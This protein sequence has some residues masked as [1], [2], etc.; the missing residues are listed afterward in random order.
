[1]MYSRW[2]IAG[3]R[4]EAP[5]ALL[6]AGY[7]PLLA[8]VLAVRGYATPEAARQFLDVDERLLGDPLMLADMPQAVMRLTRAIAAGEHIAVYGDYDV[9]GITST[10][11]LT[12]YLRRRGVKCDWYIPDRLEEGYGVNSAAIDTLKARGVTLIV[13]VDCGV[14]T[15]EEAA[16]ASG[17]GVDM[18][19]TD[20]H[21]CRDALPDAI[22]VVDPKR[23]DCLYPSHDLAGVGVAF[24]LLCALEG[25]AGTI[26]DRYADLVAVGTVADVMPLVGENRY[27]VQRGLEKL[28][29][30]PRPGLRALLEEVGLAG[31]RV[32]ATNI[33]FTLAPRLNAS[34]RL[35]QVESAMHLLLS[36]SAREAAGCAAD[37]CQLNRDRQ[38]L[39]AE[40]WQQAQ[41]MLG[42]TAPDAP[43]VLAR[44]AWHQGVIGIAASR[45][46]E[47][48]SVP[49][50]MICLDGDKGKG[51]CRSCGGFNLFTALSECSQYL[52]GFGG[53]ALA[54]GLTI[55]RENIAAFRTAFTDYYRSHAEECVSTLEI[56]L[57]ADSPGL[58][59]LQCVEDLERLEPCGTGN[60]RPRLCLMGAILTDLTP[61]GGGRHLRVRLEKFGEQYE[62]VFF[63]QTA[64]SLGVRTGDCVDAAF[65]PQINEF[66]QK[67]SV[68]LLLSDLRQHRPDAAAAILRGEIPEDAPAPARSDFESLW[69]ALSARGGEFAAAPERFCAELC[70]AL[71]EET[72]C[73]CIKVFEEL[74]LVS[75]REQRGRWTARCI[76]DAGRRT[77]GDS[78]LLRALERGEGDAY[79]ER[80]DHG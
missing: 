36:D 28:E 17:L 18:I 35:G 22:A 15:V 46:A 71:T 42:H 26:L 14:T 1:M 31:K 76:P 78:A 58:L 47:A 13:T 2:K 12:D 10:C 9:D 16:Y 66:R 56:D 33:G 80:N 24:K 68:Q 25:D 75:L 40:I 19:I 79:A 54:A 34:G 51:S 37:L 29:S 44:E 7:S 62:A 77:L 11:M 73:L 61:I 20:H 32:T 48:F 63:H 49:A 27:I 53:H 52:E 50:I 65:F 72:V 43:I 41:E 45:L 38:D 70:P 5:E 60:P 57:C 6:R 21:E 59:T 74:G 39:E 23:P 64:E 67:R 55:R 69:R 30:A 3:Q 8:A 4:A